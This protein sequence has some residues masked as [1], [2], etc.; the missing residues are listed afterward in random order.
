MYEGH[1]LPEIA[2][3]LKAEVRLD[4]SDYWQ[5]YCSNAE[6]SRCQA[7]EIVSW[8]C[9][10]IDFIPLLATTKAMRASGQAGGLIYWEWAASFGIGS[11]PSPGQSCEVSGPIITLILVPCKVLIASPYY[12]NSVVPRYLQHVSW[13]RIWSWENPFIGGA[14]AVDGRSLGGTF[15]C[16]CACW[17]F[18][19]G[20]WIIQCRRW[21]R[22]SRVWDQSE[23]HSTTVGL[24][25]QRA[26]WCCSLSIEVY[27]L[28]NNASLL[29]RLAQLH[30]KVG[31]MSRYI[32]CI[33]FDHYLNIC[34][35]RLFGRGL[36]F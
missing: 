11:H 28:W 7:A 16:A 9:L 25:Q 30:L 3:W 21:A 1:C 26:M 24:M 8:V 19:S 10:F 5:S 4:T 17:W 33:A 15:C 32:T 12:S 36:E 31:Q 20:A 34:L 6:S 2:V 13:G 14:R 18:V 35:F 23:S 27:S 29:M 22:E